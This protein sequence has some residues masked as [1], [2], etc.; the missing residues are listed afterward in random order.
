MNK[1]P[2][3]FTDT[4]VIYPSE[5]EQ[6]VWVAHSLNTDQIGTGECVLEAYVAL[7]RA[8]RALLEEAG[9][10]PKLCLL[11]P[12]PKEVRDRCK[13]ARRL[14][15]EIVEIASMMLDGKPLEGRPTYKPRYRNLSASV[16]L[17][18]LAV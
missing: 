1:V 5:L 9:K 2:A 11:N 7:L 14:P 13:H 18:E 3:E 4:F 12:A 17:A 6:G 10:N 15:L 16:N 8:L